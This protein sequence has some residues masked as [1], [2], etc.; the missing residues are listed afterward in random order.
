MELSKEDSQK[1]DLSFK[2]LLLG[3]ASI[4]KTIL[5]SRLK[6]KNYIE[7]KKIKT[8]NYQPTVGFE[9]ISQDIKVNNKII[10]LQLWDCCGNEVYASL[11]QNFYRNSSAYILCYDS[12]DRNSFEKVKLDCID[13]EKFRGE[14]LYFL[15]RTK[16]ELENKRKKDFVSDEE[17]I[18]FADENN[19]YF[20]HI[21][22]FE[23]NGT[24]IYELFTFIAARLIDNYNKS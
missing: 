12:N 9:F 1:F 3:K 13:L 22:S 4:G 24:G 11:I 17:A 18:K 21:S 8:S 16:Y 10:R 14:C 2:V 23:K 7:F 6:S 20:F 5:T 19:A 15:I